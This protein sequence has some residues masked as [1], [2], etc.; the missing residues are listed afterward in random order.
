MPISPASHTPFPLVSFTTTDDKG[1]YRFENIPAGYIVME[2]PLKRGYVPTD[3]PVK[4]VKLEDGTNS[5]NNNFMNRP[6]RSLFNI[7]FFS[8]GT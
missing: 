2:T 1:F 4:V 3:A 8:K 6:I 5:M 7:P